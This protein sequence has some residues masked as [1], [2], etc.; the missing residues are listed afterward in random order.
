MCAEIRR[1]GVAASGGVAIA[2]AFLFSPAGQPADSISAE[3][4]TPENERA[5][6]RQ[7]L[8]AARDGIQRLYAQA[9]ERLSEEDAAIFQVHEMFLQ[10]PTLLQ[11]A[12]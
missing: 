8:A 12:E 2:P 11:A 9:R 6:L 1:R 4:T 3:P 5:R 10:D 7:A